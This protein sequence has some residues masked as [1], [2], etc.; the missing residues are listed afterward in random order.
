M[1]FDAFDFLKSRQLEGKRVFE[2][3]SGGS[4]LF[5]VRQGAS[6]VSI[7]HDPL[8]YK[9]MLGLL[10]G[11]KKLDYR[12]CEPDKRPNSENNVRDPSDPDQYS[13]RDLIDLDFEHYVTQI[14]EFRDGFFDV[15]MIDGR[16]R[17]SCLKHS[18]RKIKKG[19]FLILDNADQC[20]YIAHWKT[21]YLLRGYDLKEFYGAGPCGH[22]FWQTN[23][24]TS[25]QIS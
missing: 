16:A 11:T 13:S 15:V 5:W 24:Y 4:T 18:S 22:E 19:G 3:G 2:Y 17:P 23:V 25:S 7:E 8:W 6:C 21:Q 12:L 20:Y 1:T 14:D 9:R 10:P